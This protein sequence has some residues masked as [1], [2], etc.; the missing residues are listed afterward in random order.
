MKRCG[1]G[2]RRNKRHTPGS[3][4]SEKTV[5]KSGKAQ[6]HISP[7]KTEPKELDPDSVPHAILVVSI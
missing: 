1:S 6:R 3:H 5:D 7:E 4:G 2:Q